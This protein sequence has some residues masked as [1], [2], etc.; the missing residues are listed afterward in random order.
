MKIRSYN[1]SDYP[2]VL[3]VYAASKLDELRY[4]E[5]RF[6]LLPLE[7]DPKRLGLL[8]ESEIYI[9][10]EDDIVGYCAKHGAEI[11]ALFVHPE[12]RG[13]GFGRCMLEFLLARIPGPA[14]LYVARSNGPAKNLY[15]QYGFEVVEEF[16]TSYNGLPV[17]ANKMIRPGEK[18]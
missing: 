1:T 10:E 16:E 12:S 2:A 15:M 13:K 11:R 5:A 8:L 9:C 7:N 4:E 14:N 3:A 18:P 17:F 6:T